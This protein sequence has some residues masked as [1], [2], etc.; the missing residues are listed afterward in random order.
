MIYVYIE[1]RYIRQ[2]N[3]ICP[4]VIERLFRAVEESAKKNGGSCGKLGNGYLYQFDTDVVGSVFATARFLG[5]LS[6]AFYAERDR[7]RE[8]FAVVE[9]REEPCHPEALAESFASYDT[10][11]LPDAGI[12]LEREASLALSD[13]I[14]AEA[15][16]GTKLLGF[17]GVTFPDKKKGD[18]R[19]QRKSPAHV[20]F[21]DYARDPISALKNLAC[22]IPMPALPPE[23]SQEER[24]QF[25][26]G[27]KALDVFAR[28]RFSSTQPEYRLNACVDY[29]ALYFRAANAQN[30]SS[31]KTLRVKVMGASALPAEWTPFL[32]RL[33]AS[34]RFGALAASQFAEGGIGALPDDL[35][36]LAWLLYRSVN[37]LFL[38]ELLP[39]FSSLGKEDDYVTALG[40]WLHSAG[41][42]AD[43]ENLRSLNASF[44]EDV[45]KRVGERKAG[46]DLKLASFLWTLYEKGR[47]EPVF[48]FYEVLRSLG[49]EVPDSF[50]VNCLYH[51]ANPLAALESIRARFLDP[52]IASAVE[53]LERARRLYEQGDLDEATNLAKDVLHVFQKERILTGEYRALSL[54]ALLSLARNSG[55][56]AVVYLE[57]ALENAELMHDPY[58]VLATRIDMAMVYFI[59]GNLHF[60]LCALEM[61][62]TLVE[63]HFLKDREVLLLFLRGR[64]AFELGDYRNA[65][66]LFQTAASLASVHQIPE[67]VTLSRVWYARALVHQNRFASAESILADCA[68]SV[69]DAWVFL[70][71]S[72]LVSGRAIPGVHFPDEL[73]RDEPLSSRWSLAQVSWDTGFSVAEDRAFGQSTETRI[74]ARMY[75]AMRLYYEARYVLDANVPSIVSELGGIARKALE[76]QDPY[77]SVYYYF[78]YDLGAKNPSIHPA[79][80]AGFMSR[81]FKYMQRRANEIGDNAMREQ[82][83]QSPTWNERL[84]RVARDNMLI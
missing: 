82:F 75:R 51:E 35:A 49:F 32:D 69:D 48:A 54:I 44:E 21:S 73:S 74:S 43:P 66:L 84:Y 16:E 70:V 37:L 64:I 17:A 18:E 61:A 80:T 46:L 3:R 81:G 2:L 19:H 68:G 42:V 7:V 25:A 12:F 36:D 27:K 47:I 26:E 31:T 15:I 39:F 58:S 83:M 60:A 22:A 57:Y 20:L 28:F 10:V 76:R 13:Y 34:A 62:E 71:E 40:G 1:L 67:S 78:C 30:A 63:E 9:R 56:D 33:T 77:A 45:A 8:Y 14:H 52:A 65:E 29:F 50:L 72:A 4:E 23:F 79:D 55:N 38:D 41:V 11:I 5:D 6:D 24:D 53:D 59:V